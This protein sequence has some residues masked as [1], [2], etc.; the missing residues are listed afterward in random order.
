MSEVSRRRF[1]VGGATA[2]SAARVMGA[3]DR[4]R[5]GIIGAGGRGTY[6][7][8]QANNCPNI[9]WVAVCDAWD[10]RRDKATERS[11]PQVAKYGD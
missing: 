6:L 2:V 4:V 7:M 5:L 8:G 11:G 9:A 3:N 10:V 1:L